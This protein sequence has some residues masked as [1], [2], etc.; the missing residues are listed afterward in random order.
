MDILWPGFLLLLLLIPLILAVT[1]WILRRRRRFAVRYSSLALVHAAL[2]RQSR[3]KRYLPLALF[4][5]ALASLVVALGRPVAIVSVP[6]DQTSVIMAIDVSRSMCSTDI[7][8][9]RIQA[10]EAAA[11]S[12]IQHQKAS[13]QIGIV[14]FSGFAELIQPPTTDPELLQSAIE[15]LMTGRRTAIGSGILQSL[16]AIAEIDKNVAP[17]I[18]DTSTGVAP[19]PVPPGAY[20]P[21]IIILLSDGASNAGPSPLDAAQQAADRGVRIYTIGF[22]TANGSSFPNC[23]QQFMGNEPFGGQQFGGQQFGG[24]PSGGDPF[25]GSGF[26]GGSGFGGGGFRRGIDEVTLKQI[27]AMTGGDYHSAE[28][29][30]ELQNVFQNLPTYLITKHEIM[31]ISVGFT[32]LGVLLAGAA[33]LLSMIWNPLP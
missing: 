20:V 21:D 8:P 4:L 15:S 23:P 31:E 2:P 16:D 25:G 9:S 22:G 10:A 17:S 18:S 12:F 24:P 33:I 6:T 32:A 26:Y 7:Q 14:A 19:T 13:T 1:I 30:H 29:A 27:A 5:L 11:L 3:L 28:S